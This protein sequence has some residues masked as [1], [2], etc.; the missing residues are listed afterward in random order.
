[1]SQ[2]FAEFWKLAVDSKLL[3]P[4]QCQQLHTDFSQ[5]KGALE[6]GSSKTLAEWLVSRNVI[7]RYQATILLAGRPG[8]FAY[9]D[10]RVYER[11]EAG[12]LKGQF[13]AVHAPTGH[14]TVLQFLTG[15]LTR[16]PQLWA[17][18][19]REAISNCQISSPNLQQWLDV[20]DLATFKFVVSEDLRGQSVEER[21][22]AGR[23]SPPDA[24]RWGIGVAQG[25]AHLHNAGKA[26]GD[27]RPMNIWIEAVANHPGQVKLLRDPLYVSQPV[28]FAETDASRGD[29]L[30]PE[31]IQSGKEPDVLT[32]LYSLGCVLYALLTG[33]PP[34]AGGTLEQKMRRHATEPIRPLEQYGVPQPVAQLV[35]YLMAKNPAVRYQQAAIVIEQLAP[36]VDPQLLHF[37]PP[38]APATLPAFEAWIQQK[39]SV[40]AA[41]GATAPVSSA[42]TGVA[43]NSAS[44]ETPK[45][46]IDLGK[47]ETGSKKSAVGIGIKSK[48]KGVDSATTLKEQ[49]EKKKT[50]QLILGLVGAGFLAVIA[51]IVIN[52]SGNPKQTEIVENATNGGSETVVPPNSVGGTEAKNND[53]GVKPVEVV[54]SG[55]NTPNVNPQTNNNTSDSGTAK[56]PITQPVGLQQSVV[57]DDGQLL[58]ASPTIGAPID[59]SGVPPEG[60]VF[61]ALRPALMLQTEEGKRVLS[62][63]GPE[64]EGAKATFE[65]ASGFK[66]DEV[67]RLVTTFHNNDGKFPRVS[68]VVYPVETLETEALLA[69][70]GNPAVA[71]HEGKKY[72]TGNGW[73]F[74]IPPAATG[75]VH[76]IM[77]DPA[78]IMDGLAQNSAPPILRKEVERLRRVTDA[79]RHVN[80]LFYPNFLGNND[81]L[82]L[83][84]GGRERAREPLLW[85]LGDDLQAGAVSLHFDSQFYW[86]LRFISTLSRDKYTLAKEFRERM[87]QI[88]DQV[89]TYIAGMN[90]PQYWRK[91]SMKFPPMISQMHAY[92]RI[93]VEDEAAVLNGVLPGVAAHNLILGTELA[94]LTSP[95]AGG[96]TAVATAAKPQPKTIDDI[97]QM[98]TSFAFDN[99]S[100]EFAMR[101]LATET[102]EL[103]KGSPVEFA[104]RIL[105]TDLQ[106]DGITRNMSIR[107]FK[108][109]NKPVGE[110]LTALVMKTSTNTDPAS[111]EQKLIWVVGPDP[112]NPSKQIVLITTRKKAAERGNKLPTVFAEKKT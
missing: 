35:T 54:N 83:F 107:D 72:Y 108:Q 74:A 92:T 75:D 102:G 69:K 82:P 57:P 78:T 47:I 13:R 26:H 97:L 10:Y 84:G 103:T 19:A 36:F 77:S 43:G 59:L 68:L 22:T 21:M 94:I 105:G 76:F 100:L 62:A 38:Q 6:T 104:I 27:L 24:C 9:G 3:S 33:N 63:L 46:G 11:I 87:E 45:V 32:D 8:P 112:D 93:G 25:L 1:M 88:P 34:F 56:S 50:Q 30:A 89:L 71:E 70:L 79:E 109:E 41:K 48:D 14:P 96:G 90:V 52:Y 31:F 39:R 67:D 61:V 85:L 106:L 20:V 15:N 4:Q 65:K 5:I 60:Q 111:P 98:K 23:I 64:L 49:N 28:N 42:A 2:S 7:S 81:G 101:D 80:V 99:T 44:S 40:L 53:T 58:W 37:P 29:Y 110:I 73:A 51:L 16:D 17:K 66:L 95:G 86:E 91:L 55:S 12:R 18:V